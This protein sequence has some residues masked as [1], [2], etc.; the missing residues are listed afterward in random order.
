MTA[1]RQGNRRTSAAPHEFPR[2]TLEIDGR[3]ALACRP[4]PCGAVV[5][6]LQRD[7]VAFFLVSGDGGPRLRLCQWSCS[8]DRR[9][10]ARNGADENDRGN[11]GSCGHTSPPQLNASINRTHVVLRSRY[12]TYYNAYE[13][14]FEQTDIGRSPYPH[15]SPNYRQRILQDASDRID[16]LLFD[17]EGRRK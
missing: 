8:G 3:R 11:S 13:K 15:A 16:L 9:Q 12:S 6:A 10:G 7:A 17:D 1:V 14:W 4:G 2:V 5:L